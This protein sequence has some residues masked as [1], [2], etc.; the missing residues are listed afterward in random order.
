MF[1]YDAV[2]F[3]EVYVVSNGDF[4][5]ID[6]KYNNLSNEHEIIANPLTTTITRIKEDNENCDEIPSFASIS[7][8]IEI[9]EIS[10]KFKN[11]EI[12]DQTF[13]DLFCVIYQIGNV[14]EKR[15]RGSDKTSKYQVISVFDE[16]RHLIDITFWGDDS[17]KLLEL[18]PNEVI[19]FKSYIF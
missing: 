15:S 6:K 17:V 12:G 1:L 8:F 18:N 19:F 4:K 7:N 2:K 13:I 11:C 5:I 14:Q 3:N 16:S 9:K 10:S